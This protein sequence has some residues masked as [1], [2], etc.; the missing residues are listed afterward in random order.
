MSEAGVA[1]QAGHEEP[2]AN[3]CQ[4]FEWP[5]GGHI[6]HARYEGHETEVTTCPVSVVRPRGQASL[7]SVVII[8]LHSTLNTLY[9]V[10]AVMTII[11]ITRLGTTIV[12]EF[13][14]YFREYRIGIA[15]VEL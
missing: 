13:P 7:A 8:T 4:Q 3:K 2:L 1:Q 6:R 12:T 10:R 15:T 9:S 11:S 14:K 5:V